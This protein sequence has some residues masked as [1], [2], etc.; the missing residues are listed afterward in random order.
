MLSQKRV[1]HT[2]LGTVLAVIVW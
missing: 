2:K 1:M